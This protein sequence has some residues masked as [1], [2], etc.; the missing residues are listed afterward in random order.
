MRITAQLT[1]RIT[2][3]PMETKE[4]HCRIL[5]CQEVLTRLLAAMPG[6]D[7]VCNVKNVLNF[8]KTIDFVSLFALV[9][10][11]ISL[12]SLGTNTTERATKLHTDILTGFGDN[13]YLHKSQTGQTCKL[14]PDSLWVFIPAHWLL[15]AVHNVDF[16]LAYT[17]KHVMLRWC[18]YHLSRQIQST[19]N[20]EQMVCVCGGGVSR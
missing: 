16:L 19:S 9:K 13:T 4:T 1:H 14:E 3:K 11:N 20:S 2:H 12:H 10:H 5:D 8:T 6:L 17:L 7:T 15:F 18:R